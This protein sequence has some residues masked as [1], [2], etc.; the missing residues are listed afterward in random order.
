V[1]GLENEESPRALTNRLVRLKVWQKLSFRLMIYGVGIG[2]VI[3][4]LLALPFFLNGGC[5]IDDR[6]TDEDW[7][8]V[9]SRLPPPFAR[10]FDLGET[11]F[12]ITL[13]CWTIGGV[14]SLLAWSIYSGT[15]KRT[16]KNASLSFEVVDILAQRVKVFKFGLYRSV[17]CIMGDL[18]EQNA[19]PSLIEVLKS[20]DHR[21]RMEAAKALGNLKVERAIVPLTQALK[22]ASQVD[23]RGAHSEEYFEIEK[24]LQ[25]LNAQRQ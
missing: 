22:D 24:A 23:A 21:V 20:P 4:F 13:T 14:S 5:S 2:A 8:R 25:K 10:A 19:T 16:I 1:T 6:S 3:C 7:N 12:I 9:Y 17:I 11:V 18:G 15:R